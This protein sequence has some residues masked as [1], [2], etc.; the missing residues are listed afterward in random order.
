[1]NIMIALTFVVIILWLFALTYTVAQIVK[2]LAKTYEKREMEED[3]EYD[4]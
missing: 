1:M 2:I 4:D 3:Y